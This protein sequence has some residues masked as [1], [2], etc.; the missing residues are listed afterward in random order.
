MTSWKKIHKRRV[1][2][3]CLTPDILRM[4]TQPNDKTLYIESFNNSFYFGDQI[5]YEEEAKIHIFSSTN[6]DK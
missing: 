4:G 5:E 2:I 6:F 1:V 3:G